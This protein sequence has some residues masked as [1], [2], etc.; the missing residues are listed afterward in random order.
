MVGI[1]ERLRPNVVL[2]DVN[3]P[4]IDGIDAIRILR[5]H[6]GATAP[7]VVALTARTDVLRVAHPFSA[8]LLKP[9]ERKQ[10]EAVLQRWLAHSAD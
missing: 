2:M 1:V 3:L 5:D 9:L 6:M 10:L 7:P 8:V 4:G